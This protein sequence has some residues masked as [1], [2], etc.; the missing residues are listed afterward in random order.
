MTKQEAIDLII[1]KLYQYAM[2]NGEA[3]FEMIEISH[4]VKHIIERINENE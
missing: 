2:N 3:T 1:N 4:Y